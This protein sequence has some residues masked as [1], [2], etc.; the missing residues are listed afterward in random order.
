MGDPN[1]T[2]DYD[3]VKTDPDRYSPFR[4]VREAEREE[5]GPQGDEDEDDDVLTGG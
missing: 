1:T 2:H 5:Q 4:S 3:K